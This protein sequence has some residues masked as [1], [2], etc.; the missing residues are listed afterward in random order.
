MLIYLGDI[1][2]NRNSRSIR[3][4][5][6]K[7]KWP[8]SHLADASASNNNVDLSLHVWRGTWQHNQLVGL[9]QCVEIDLKGRPVSAVRWFMGQKGKRP[10]LA[11]AEEIAAGLAPS[12]SADDSTAQTSDLDIFPVD[13]WEDLNRDL[14]LVI[15]DALE[16]N[17]A[18][19]EVFTKL[20]TSP[21][22][23]RLGLQPSTWQYFDD[24]TNRWTPY[25][26]RVRDSLEQ[27][28]ERGIKAVTFA[29]D[30]ETS[31]DNAADDALTGK[32]LS[33]FDLHSM[34]ETRTQHS[35][36]P[37]FLVD[38]TD[39]NV[40]V[41]GLGG[42]TKTYRIRRSEGID[43][44][45]AVVADGDRSYAP[46]DVSIDERGWFMD[47]TTSRGANAVGDQVALV[48]ANFSMATGRH[49]WE[50]T[51]LATDASKKALRIGVL[52]SDQIAGAHSYLGSTTTQWALGKDGMKWTNNEPS[53]VDSIT[54][55]AKG[56]KVK[57]L[58]DLNADVPTIS[59]TLN[60]GAR[61]LAYELPKGCILR[62][63][64]SLQPGDQLRWE[65]LSKCKSVWDTRN[66]GQEAKPCPD[67]CM[68]VIKHKTG[69]ENG[70]AILVTPTVTTVGKDGLEAD[71][72]KPRTVRWS[73][74]V[75]QSDKTTVG[76]VK[77][78]FRARQHGYVNKTLNGWGYYQTDG[79]I[80]H[81]ASAGT[82]YGDPYQ[83]PGDVITGSF[84][85][86]T[87]LS[88]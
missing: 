10:R 45:Q 19:R 16:V 63:A 59:F 83:T 55:V 32:L 67:D 73:F 20:N 61:E 27:A 43:L 74:R 40:N 14:R 44:R 82:N 1:L 8:P 71:D 86:F 51:I 52:V 53:P 72:D 58:L 15:T 75:N 76:L 5:D 78:S 3:I 48:P 68:T 35:K 2:F 70:S 87:R 54:R 17:S 41:E 33:N 84:M 37:S 46:L 62:P 4:G 47:C 13:S 23:R 25:A 9:A 11:K 39:A 36:V 49:E 81:G 28:R 34:I 65:F 26:L 30:V 57:V 31:E 29:I 42:F 50:V 79:K 22:F 18:L 24:Q 69:W 6:N 88:F 85:F 80:G 64:F 66:I 56:D 38:T 21:A 60:K 7:V 77:K 12:K